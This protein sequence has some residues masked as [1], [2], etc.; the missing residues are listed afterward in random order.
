MLGDAGKQQFL[1]A[2]WQEVEDIITDD[3][4]VMIIASNVGGGCEMRFAWRKDED[5]KWKYGDASAMLYGY[6]PGEIPWTVWQVGS[7]VSPD[8]CVKMVRTRLKKKR[9]DTEATE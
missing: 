8:E 2:G 6:E 1:D 3:A 5:G 4:R 9:V 7:A